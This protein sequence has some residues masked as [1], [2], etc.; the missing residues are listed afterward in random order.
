MKPYRKNNRDRSVKLFKFFAGVRTLVYDTITSGP[1]TLIGYSLSE[2]KRKT[3]FVSIPGRN[4]EIDLAIN[5]TDGDPRYENRTFKATLESSNGSRAD[6]EELINDLVNTVEGRYLV[7]MSPDD[8]EHYMI[9]YAHVAVEYNDLNHC[10][11]ILSG[12]VAPW[13]E[14]LDEVYEE[15]TPT[16]TTQYIYLENRGGRPVAPTFSVWGTGSVTLTWGYSSAVTINADDEEV[17]LTDLMMH[18]KDTLRIA[19]TGDAQHVS[20]RYREAIL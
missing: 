18:Y 12:N 1:W 3:N 8:Q 17:T 5:Q 15:I 14:A 7:I 10:R 19:Y 20:Y 4:G 6:R 2:P 11:V 13:R 16:S 9:G